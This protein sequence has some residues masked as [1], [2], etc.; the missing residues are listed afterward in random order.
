VFIAGFIGGVTY[1]LA[2]FC[3]TDPPVLP[4]LTA[5]DFVDLIQASD[6]FAKTAAVKKINDWIGYYVWF[7]VCKCD[8]GAQPTPTSTQ[9]QPANLP[10]VN[11]PTVVPN[12][13]SPCYSN[14]LVVTA[15]QFSKPNTIGPQPLGALPLGATSCIFDVS[16]VPDPAGG[17]GFT[18]P[19]Q[20]LFTSTS[21]SNLAIGPIY[22]VSIPATSTHIRS[23]LQIPAGA[24]FLKYQYT[25]T[26]AGTRIDDISWFFDFY[27]GPQVGQ[28]PPCC[29]DVGSA[30]EIQQIL[31]LVTLIQRQSVPFA[32]V[33][34]TVH[35][36]L[37]GSG[38]LN[39]SGLLGMKLTITTDPTT[40]GTEGSSPP[41]LFDRGYF[42]WGTPDGYP[43]SERLERTNQLSLPARCSAFTDFAYDFHPGVVV[44]ATELVREP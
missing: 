22:T 36:G 38:V 19:L 2:T 27:C 5:Q 37:S 31:E 35:A 39:V 3:S 33:P 16:S 11:P 42:T 17:G 44:T 15:Q 28:A 32:Y 14:Q 7:D 12:V 26:S 40:L 4:T 43:Q 20:L 18:L 9:A 24:T 29:G 8:V 30:L 13:G 21:V 34:G 25:E 10:T 1:E 23:A 6:F 41:I